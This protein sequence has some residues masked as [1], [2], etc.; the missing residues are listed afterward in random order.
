MDMNIARSDRDSAQ[1]VTRDLKKQLGEKKTEE[2]LLYVFSSVNT[3]NK[4]LISTLASSFSDSTIIGTSTAG[5]IYNEDV[6]TGEIV[7]VSLEG[8][9]ELGVS[10]VQDEK[11][12]DVEKAMKAAGEALTELNEDY[13]VARELK[14][15]GIEWKQENPVKLSVFATS[16]HI[17]IEKII[18]GIKNVTGQRIDVTGGLAGDSW[19]LNET[20]VFHN[21]NIIRNGLIVAAIS[22]KHQITHSIKN[23]LSI[24]RETNFEVTDFEEGKIKGLDGEPPKK[25]YQEIYGQKGAVKNFV[26]T[27]PLAAETI[28]E[29]I[30]RTPI[31]ID[32]EGSFRII[33]G[34]PKDVL[35]PVKQTDESLIN[36]AKEAAEEAKNKITD[37]D[38]II[39]GA[40][41][42]SSV[43]RWNSLQNEETRRKEIEAVKEVIGKK[44][45]VGW[46]NYG[47]VSLPDKHTGIHNNG[48]IVELITK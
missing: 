24:D 14:R 21:G 11:I 47:Q 13:V 29:P 32:E 39:K 46:Y 28:D 48:I 43:L 12:D 25:V 5:E 18:E 4:Y 45:I 31:N 37:E 6:K 20:Y 19:R 3:L 44:P 8:D 27:K 16:L 22:T 9:F 38:T 26:M 10:S 1:K 41:L 2:R 7:V 35:H 15:E 17:N 30:V 42:H 23:G 33:G 34:L 40:I 36:A